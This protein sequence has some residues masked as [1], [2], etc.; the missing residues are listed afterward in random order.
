MKLAI[1]I[2]L[3]LVMLVICVWLV[4]PNPH[5]QVELASTIRSLHFA[6][7]WPYLAGY[8]VL[9]AVTHF[10]RAWR[11]NNLLEPI[12]VRLPAGRLLAISSVGF[13]AILALPARLGEFVRPALI[14]KKG[15]VSA[16]AALGTVAVERIVDGL[17]VSIFVFGALFAVR[18]PD[19]PP[20]MMPAAYGAL[21]IFAAAL[22][23]LLFALRWPHETVRFSVRL[24]LLPQISPRFAGLVEQKLASMISGFLVLKDRRNLLIFALWSLV[25]W[26]ANGF[27]LWVLAHG[28]HLDLSLFGAFAVMGLVAVGITLPN[29]PGLVGQYQYFTQQGLALYLGKAIGL[30][31]QGLAFALVLHGMQVVWYV[32]IGGIA[33]ATPYISFAEIWHSRDDEVEN[34]ETAPAGAPPK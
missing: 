21:G 6:E 32:V 25:Y 12:G 23:F 7:F 33:L 29:A 30:G 10:C 22:V 26:V 4:W 13:L 14:R 31:G 18:G 5:K 24:T 1:N 8:L 9:L 15:H 17:L 20:W 34:G 11:W 2:S 16:A 27:S 3:S 28:M 19:S